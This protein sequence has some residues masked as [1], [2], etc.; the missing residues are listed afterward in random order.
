MPA[1]AVDQLIE[2][3]D[4]GFAPT[5]EQSESTPY[6]DRLLLPVREPRS[7]PAAIFTLR[8]WSLYG[9]RGAIGGNWRQIIQRRNRRNE[10]KRLPPAATGCRETRTG[11]PAQR[12]AVIGDS[13]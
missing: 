9:V 8:R 12:T 3:A 13:A 5:Q 2:N 7:L 6:G 1:S 4:F 10:R 11:E